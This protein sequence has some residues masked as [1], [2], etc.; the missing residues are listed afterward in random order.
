MSVSSTTRTSPAVGYIRMSTNDQENSPGRQKAEIEKFAKTQGYRIT[1]WYEDHGITGTESVNRKEF[2]LLLGDA[3]SGKIRAVIL[4]EISRGSREEP[5]EAMLHWRLLSQAGVK[6]LS[7]QKGG[8]YK[9]DDI[10]GLITLMVDQFGAHD[11]AVKFSKR[12]SSGK[13]ELL[14][15][16]EYCFNNAFGFDRE[17]IDPKGEIVRRVSAYEKFQKPSGWKTKRVVTSDRPVVDAIKWAFESVASGE[18]GIAGVVSEFDRL[19]IRTLNGAMWSRTSVKNILTNHTMTGRLLVGKTA[20]NGVS[21]SKFSRVVPNGEVME[22]SHEAIVSEDLFNRVQKALASKIT[23]RSDARS[24]LL[25]GVIYCGECNEVMYGS[26][27]RGNHRYHCM[28]APTRSQDCSRPSLGAIALESSIIAIIKDYILTDEGLKTISQRVP[29]SGV[30]DPTEVA[31][32][33]LNDQIER[34]VE[35]LALAS[36]EDDFRGMSL[37]LSG[38][39]SERDKLVKKTISSTPEPSMVNK[40]D[41]RLIRENIDKGD[42]ALLKMIVQDC[43]ER[44]TIWRKPIGDSYDFCGEVALREE[45]YSGQPIP[46]SD[47]Q[48]VPQPSWKKLRRLL[49]SEDRWFCSDEIKSLIGMSTDEMFRAGRYAVEYGVCEKEKRGHFTYYRLNRF[50]VEDD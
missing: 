3:K 48:I 31:I 42:P 20:R 22:V 4:S 32:S 41:L 9:F 5:L 21:H 27:G 14:K 28:K 7:V 26:L 30:T 49:Q 23:H 36:S 50:C 24:Y 2:Q 40:K 45:V 19:Q 29:T 38:W 1:K 15:R 33:K 8:E 10:G 11:E 46:L 43:I 17:I 39:R 25:S 12:S 47:E 18:S 35:N 13:R 6:L 44:V 16:G 34:G 37:L